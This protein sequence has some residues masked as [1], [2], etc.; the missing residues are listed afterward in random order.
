M[1]ILVSECKIELMNELTKK[2]ESKYGSLD[3]EVQK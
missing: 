2:F 3:K 1:R